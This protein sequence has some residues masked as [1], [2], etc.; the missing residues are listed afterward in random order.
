MIQ[1]KQLCQDS[2][3]RVLMIV[4]LYPYPVLGGLE[5]QAHELARELIDLGFDVQALSGSNGSSTVGIELVDGVK[6]HRIRWVHNKFLR[7][8]LTP[9]DLLF[10]LIKLR[11]TFDVVHLHQCSWFGLFTIILAKI[12]GKPVLTKLPSSGEMGIVGMQSHIFGWLKVRI[13]KMS[14][15][16][17]AMSDAS[18]SEIQAVDYSTAKVLNTSNGIKKMR[19]EAVCDREERD[20]PLKVVFVGRLSEEKR[21][22]TLIDAWISVVRNVRPT[23]I[24]EF[25]GG[26]ALEEHLKQRCDSHGISSYVNFRGHVERVRE[27]LRSMDVFV[28]P[29]VMEGNSNAIL[30]AMEAGLPIVSTAVG[31]TP[32]LV[33]MAG[34][35]FLFDVGDA[36]TLSKILI[37][38]LSNT[39][40]R[41]E[42]GRS[43]R[44]RVEQYFDI[45][46]VANNYIS[47]YRCLHSR[48]PTSL[49]G[50]SRLP[51]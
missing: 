38:L 36:D 47:A 24:L 33:G 34:R 7:F 22:D 25:F 15:G 29:S 51:S 40:L 42:A 45:R 16:L 1:S 5:K 48:R 17:V 10:E 12:L 31:G 50:L 30:E 19:L 37:R 44:S 43:M 4:P 39:N 46:V 3:P 41:V 6:V 8:L 49:G 27:L 9:F 23:P 21:I 2:D 14:D 28:L 35:E 32:M 20:G 18:V 26:G 11:C 13:L